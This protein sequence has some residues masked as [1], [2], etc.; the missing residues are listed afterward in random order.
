MTSEPLQHGQGEMGQ[1]CCVAAKYQC[2]CH[3]EISEG[4]TV[5]VILVLTLNIGDTDEQHDLK[6][7]LRILSA[8][9]SNLSA[10]SH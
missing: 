9:D 5:H 2:G 4:P 6:F 1:M 7:C 3:T 10:N 8:T